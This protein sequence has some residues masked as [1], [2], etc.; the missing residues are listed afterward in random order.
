MC[1]KRLREELSMA[2]AAAYNEQLSEIAENPSIKKQNRDEFLSIYGPA[3]ADDRLIDY[4][5][6]RSARIAQ[7]AFKNRN[8]DSS[9]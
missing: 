2:M 4:F 1:V 6:R 5:A 3:P 7:V 9:R 8:G